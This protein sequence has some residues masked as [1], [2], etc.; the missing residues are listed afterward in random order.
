MAKF[1]CFVCGYIFDEEQAGIPFS[2]ITECP[3]CAESRDIFRRMDEEEEKPAKEEESAKEDGDA[4]KE[5]DSEKKD[6][7][8]YLI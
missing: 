5:A 6:S 7:E 2:E 1:K 4:P 8:V 3:I